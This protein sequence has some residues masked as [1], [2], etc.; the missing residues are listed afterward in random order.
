MEKAVEREDI[1][2]TVSLETSQATRVETCAFF[3]R[4]HELVQE[5][6]TSLLQ[7]EIQCTKFFVT[8]YEI[9]TSIFRFCM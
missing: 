3:S 7:I 1:R 6:M 9:E 4:L 8:C 5:G 2:V